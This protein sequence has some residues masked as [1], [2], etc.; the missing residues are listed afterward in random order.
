MAKVVQ[1][2][3]DDDEYRTLRAILSKK[4]LSLKEG[5][6]MAVRKLL[7]EETEIDPADSFL[8]SRPFGRSHRKD[9][10]TAHDKYLY[11]E[12]RR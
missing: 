8:S 12:A 7:L 2:T 11:G 3:L 10:S 5:L 9:I 4:K 6:H 1:T